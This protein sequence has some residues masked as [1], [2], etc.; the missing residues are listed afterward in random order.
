MHRVVQRGAESRVPVTTQ[1]ENSDA[2]AILGIDRDA[3]QAQI[4][5]AYRRLSMTW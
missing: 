2:Y 1:A 3:T 5:K 4:R